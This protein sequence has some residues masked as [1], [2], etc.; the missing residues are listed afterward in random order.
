MEKLEFN[1]RL[2]KEPIDR[3]ML[4]RWDRE[5]GTVGN[6]IVFMNFFVI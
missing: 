6:E 5:L 2:V 4:G 1:I 3:L